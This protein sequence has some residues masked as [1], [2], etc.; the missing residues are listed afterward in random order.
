MHENREKYSL[1]QY[2]DIILDRW[3]RS[4]IW[5]GKYDSDHLP[6][7]YFARPTPKTVW[8]PGKPRKKYY[9][10]L[11]YKLHNTINTINKKY[12]F[13][14][15]TYHTHK[16]SA[17]QAAMLFPTHIKEFFRLLRKKI[18]HIEY[19]WVI[20]LTQAGYPHCHLILDR[21]VHWRVIRAIWYKVSKS[22]ITDIRAI[23]AGN[24]AH[25]VTKYVT[26]QSKQSQDQFAFIFKNVAR[27]WSSS[28]HFF[29]KCPDRVKDFIFVAMSFNLYLNNR[30][31]FRP[32]SECELWQVPIDY[33]APCLIYTTFIERRI[34]PK[35]YE[36]IDAYLALIPNDVKNM[37]IDNMDR[38]F[39]NYDSDSDLT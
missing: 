5:L 20:E 9:R 28:R 27:L 4:L 24:I 15:L 33:G 22:Y 3:N 30:H 16:Y 12:V 8:L 31:L 2:Q 6:E 21:Y 38:F 39:H 37:Q 34:N 26:K 11:Y 1:E 25:Y 10:H 23:P 18:G 7:L 13:G 36:F 35:A 17:A 29:T 19:F 32:D 14:T